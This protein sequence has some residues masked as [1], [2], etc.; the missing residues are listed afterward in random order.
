MGVE[1]HLQRPFTPGALLIQVMT[2]MNAGLG[3]GS[4]GGAD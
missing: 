1:A 3:L 4:V 2:T